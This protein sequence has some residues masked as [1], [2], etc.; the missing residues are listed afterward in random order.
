MS[1]VVSSFGEF[2]S[3]DDP[4]IH[5][6]DAAIGRLVR[7]M[8]VDSYRMLVLVREFDDRFGWKKGLKHWVEGGE[9]IPDNMTLR[10]THHHGLPH[11]GAF[12]IVKDA[13]GA[14][15]S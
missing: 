3:T 10:C 7:Q 14:S 11:K 4:S 9:T 12:S 2:T 8:N 13:D 6:L 5:E 15:L 1:A